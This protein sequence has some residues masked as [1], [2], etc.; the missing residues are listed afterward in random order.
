M[1]VLFELLP[2]GI[3]LNVVDRPPG[4]VFNAIGCLGS[5]IR[6]FSGRVGI[7]SSCV[8][9]EDSTLLGYS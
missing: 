7:C 4:G 8:A 2:K 6:D 1:N 5:S 3:P 9:H